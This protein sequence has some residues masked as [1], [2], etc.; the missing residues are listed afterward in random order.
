MNSLRYHGCATVHTCAHGACLN[1]SPRMGCPGPIKRKPVI[2]LE[3]CVFAE[4]LYST[5]RSTRISVAHS[6]PQQD[7][8][9]S[10]PGFKWSV[11]L[12]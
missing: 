8:T 1:F 3:L 7:L 2:E 4:I 12:K 10:C 9:L 5:E 11:E 6:Q